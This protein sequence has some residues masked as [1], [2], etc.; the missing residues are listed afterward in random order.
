M[1]MSKH[2]LGLDLGVGSIGW[3]LI[4]LD[5]QGDPAEILGMGSRV[6]P[7]N[8]ATDAADFS[9]GK[10]SRRTKS[11][12]APYDAPEALPAISCVATACVGSWRRS[13][14]SLMLHSIQL[15]LLELWGAPRAGG[16]RW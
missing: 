5:A 10:P 12:R 2:V 14:C 9:V 3:C 7:L 6:V 13:G 16:Y 11:G 1:L 8:N 4:A 15:P